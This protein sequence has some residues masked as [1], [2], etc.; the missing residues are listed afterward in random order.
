MLNFNLGEALPRILIA[1]N[2]Y[3]KNL[4]PAGWAEVANIKNDNLLLFRE[5]KCRPLDRSD[6]KNKKEFDDCKNANPIWVPM[7]TDVINPSEGRKAKNLNSNGLGVI[8]TDHVPFDLIGYYKD[9]ISGCEEE[10]HIIYVGLSF[11]GTGYHI[12]YERNRNENIPDGQLRIASALGLTQWWDQ[13][14]VDRSRALYLTHNRNT[15]YVNPAK[16]YFKNQAEK[17]EII[18]HFNQIDNFNEKKHF[19]QKN[20]SNMEKNNLQ[21]ITP[22]SPQFEVPTQYNGINFKDLM[23]A[24]LRQYGIDYP[25]V[26]GNR[27][28]AAFY[29]ALNLKGIIPDKYLTQVIPTFGLDNTEYMNQISSG[30]KS[31]YHAGRKL[32]AAISECRQSLL[33]NNPEIA[34]HQLDLDADHIAKPNAPI[35]ELMAMLLQGL[36]EE[37]RTATAFA[38]APVLGTYMTDIRFKYPIDH[39][40]QTFSFTV[41]V[42]GDQAS[43]KSIVFDRVNVAKQ[44]LWEHDQHVAQQMLAYKK[45]M[46]RIEH[47]GLWNEAPEEPEQ[48]YRLLGA[49]CSEAKAIQKMYNAKGHH[50]LLAATEI[51]AFMSNKK[52]D[53][54]LNDDII[55]E[56]FDNE[57]HYIDNK[58]D[59]TPCMPVPVKLNLIVTGT[60]R[61]LECFN[62]V[63]DGTTTRVIFAHL[64]EQ[65]GWRLPDI[66]E[67]TDIELAKIETLTKNLML[68]QGMRFSPIVEQAI[69]DWIE[70]KY[71]LGVEIGS[72]AI[73]TLYRRNAVIGYR[74][75]I[76]YCV[77]F[78]CARV[79]RDMP[80]DEEKEYAA[81]QWA[82]YFAE[83]NFRRQM[84]LYG[85]KYENLDYSKIKE[86]TTYKILDMVGEE[87]TLQE[88]QAT[89]DKIGKYPRSAHKLTDRW[90]RNKKI[91]KIKPG[92]YKKIS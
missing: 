12:V 43:G 55:K 67:Y 7:A 29:L 80:L 88:L 61:Y 2:K 60:P 32:Q 91:T 39:H 52:H 38:V 44:A 1:D 26:E 30:Y 62:D 34:T 19:I 66:P 27:A 25:V 86:S 79:L 90:E 16:F 54:A 59:D 35:P 53:Y 71:Q 49:K 17:E 3:G 89:C 24:I 45:E 65:F 85:D 42:T 73:M 56:A 8:D 69:R 33:Q 37:F 36:P 64:P 76:M 82:V 81:A 87:F 78:G 72:K 10:L 21:Q 47:L 18:N 4:R 75:G 68:Q 15:L 40:T 77:L 57:E 14:C 28:N 83:Y 51:S 13:K 6:P 74:M 22:S 11:S 20:M 50:L 9:R 5:N 58:Q 70:E 46:K 31:E 92:Y 48:D 63:E 84:T 41:V 23:P